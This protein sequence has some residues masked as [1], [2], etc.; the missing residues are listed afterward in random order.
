MMPQP[1]TKPTPAWRSLPRLAGLLALLA[2]PALAQAPAPTAPG[3]PSSPA[4]TAPDRNSSPD[5]SDP[6]P[7]SGVI[8]PPA[9]GQV[10]PGIR[11]TVPDPRPNTTPVIP[12]PG[13]PGGN[14][15]I[16]PR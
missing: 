8:Q 1:P 3:N 14:P 7:R 5:R 4:P 12:P 13:T 11:T 2:G 10:D 15:Q 6:I 9:T 16:Q